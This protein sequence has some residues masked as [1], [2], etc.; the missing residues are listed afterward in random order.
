MD[1]TTTPT[2][3]VI[4]CAKPGCGTPTTLDQATY[5]DRCGHICPACVGPLPTWWDDIDPP[6]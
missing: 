6:Y 3:A 5:V 1:T 2:S 4:T